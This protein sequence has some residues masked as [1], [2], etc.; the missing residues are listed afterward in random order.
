MT[1]DADVPDE[2]DSRDPG[3]GGSA[4]VQADH[5]PRGGRGWQRHAGL[6]EAG[7]GR[8]QGRPEPRQGRE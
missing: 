2:D 5:P 4:G 7:G 1:Q 6:G 8:L 3:A